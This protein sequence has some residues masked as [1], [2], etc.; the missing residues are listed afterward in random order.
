MS[1]RQGA[2]W[3]LKT[4][5]VE[6]DPI[7]VEGRELVPLIRMTSRVRRTA[8]LSKGGVEAHGWGFVQLRPVA[9]LDRSDDGERRLAI[10]DQ[11]A[12]WIGGLLLIAL[13]VPCVAATLMYLSRRLSDRRP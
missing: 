8:V 11:T 10:G 2:E 7:H 12:R 13:V 6:G 5:T 1:D 3:P 4:E 9:L